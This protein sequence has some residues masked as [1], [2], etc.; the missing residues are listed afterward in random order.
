MYKTSMKTVSLMLIAASWKSHATHVVGYGAASSAL[1]PAVPV[2]SQDPE[3]CVAVV[4]RGAATDQPVSTG[5]VAGFWKVDSVY[6]DLGL[7]ALDW[8]K[9]RPIPS[10]S[11]IVTEDRL[12]QWGLDEKS[13]SLK[14]VLNESKG[15]PYS[16]LEQ[17][18]PDDIDPETWSK[19]RL[20]AQSMDQF[21]PPGVPVASGANLPHGATVSIEGHRLDSRL[22]ATVSKDHVLF[23][24]D[25]NN[26]LFGIIADSRDSH[27]GEG[28]FL[29]ESGTPS[30]AGIIVMQDNNL[31][32]ATKISA[33]SAKEMGVIAI[34]QGGAVSGFE[35]FFWPNVTI[36]I[37]GDPIAYSP[38]S[39][40]ISFSTKRSEP[41]GIGSAIWYS[42]PMNGELKIVGQGDTFLPNFKHLGDR[43]LVSVPVAFDKMRSDNG[44]VQ[45]VVFWPSNVSGP[46]RSN[47]D[48]RPEASPSGTAAPPVT[49]LTRGIFI[50]SLIIVISVRGLTEI[51]LFFNALFEIEAWINPEDPQPAVQP[52]VIGQPVVAQV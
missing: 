38:M 12:G 48:Q 21:C 27:Y 22:Q 19:L 39:I 35:D 20:L 10:G 11:L 23:T 18:K 26:A 33:A 52:V 9:F 17:P 34:E 6:Q 42:V 50:V 28:V 15:Q 25:P 13:L 40:Q 29:D 3:V 43:I 32:V 46:V 37:N 30:L 41:D 51:Y 8:L 7:G 2:L 47:S 24:Y 5:R 1:R 16:I 44:E 4:A 45:R 14:K 36:E 49:E 31:K